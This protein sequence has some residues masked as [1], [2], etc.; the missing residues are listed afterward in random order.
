[1]TRARTTIV[2]LVALAV[3][4][5]VTSAAAAPATPA[6]DLAVVHVFVPRSGPGANC[7]RVYPL[8]RTVRKSAVLTGA[9]RALL[10]GPTAAERA[11]GYGGWFS[12]KT[13]NKLHAVHI[14]RGVAYVDFYDFRRVIPN[15]SSSRGSALL[16]AELNTTAT[17]FPS[18][19]RAVYSFN[20]DR[21]GFYEWLQRDAPRAGSD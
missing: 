9:M 12:S 18:V 2:A 15:A 11:R 4:C 6:D 10:A 19:R 3:A 14:G 20:G 5:G 7:A 1:M 8:K 16:L 13:A 17:Q 21:R